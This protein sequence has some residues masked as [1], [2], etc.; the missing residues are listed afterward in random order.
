M[1]REASKDH[2]H[3]H[4]HHRHHHHRHH[5]QHSELAL[6]Q[7]RW[8]DLSNDTS[9]LDCSYHST[10]IKGSI[11]LL[12]SE[13]DHGDF[14]LLVDSM[15][16]QTLHVP[17]P[18]GVDWN[19]SCQSQDADGVHAMLVQLS[20]VDR[21]LQLK[22]KILIGLPFDDHTRSQKRAETFSEA[23]LLANLQSGIMGN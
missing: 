18:F 3:H 15:D 22:V 10:T 7:I 14:Q 19:Y 13:T 11:D 4:H 8:S 2:R 17:L 23:I 16:G 12:R 20:F 9:D 1:K 5:K 21:S 6:F